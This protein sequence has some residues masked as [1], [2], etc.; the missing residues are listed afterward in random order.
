MHAR[1]VL[2]TFKPGMIDSAA[3]KADAGLAPIYRKHAGFKSYEVVKTG[4]DTAISVST[5]DSEAH[6]V[7][8]VKLG[9][10]WVAAN[11]ANDV[12]SAETHVGT[13]VIS[14]R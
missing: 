2:Y 1:V 12:V 9:A 5:W 11:I 13:V 4:T 3:K 6:A 10:E 14:H 8:A 7:E